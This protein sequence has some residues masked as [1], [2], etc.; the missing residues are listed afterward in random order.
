MIS[1]NLLYIMTLFTVTLFALGT[2]GTHSDEAIVCI[3]FVVCNCNH[4]QHCYFSI[5]NHTLLFYLKIHVQQLKR[6]F[7]GLLINYVIL[8]VESHL[9][10]ISMWIE[11]N[12]I[13]KI[14]AQQLFTFY[15]A[16]M[17]HTILYVEFKNLHFS[18]HP[19]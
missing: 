13:C 10:C 19:K 5:L 14:M 15:H 4:L 9:V 3:T 12:K 11:Q 6:F 7:S 16:I 2:L 1:T 18:S 17:L 8:T